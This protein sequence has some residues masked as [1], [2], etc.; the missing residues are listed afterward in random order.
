MNIIDLTKRF[1]SVNNVDNMILY[2]NPT[3][4]LTKFMYLDVLYD[5]DEYQMKEDCFIVF[6]GD[7]IF[8]IPVDLTLYQE[9]IIVYKN[10]FTIDDSVLD[11]NLVLSHDSGLPDSVETLLVGLVSIDSCDEISLSVFDVDGENDTGNLYPI[12]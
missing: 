3:M 7:D 5:I 12:Q 11:A 1:A 4:N 8:K 6:C 10:P 2:V 9:S